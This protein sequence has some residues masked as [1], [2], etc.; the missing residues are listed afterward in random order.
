LSAAFIVR[1]GAAVGRGVEEVIAALVGV[2]W[3][4]LMVAMI[5]R[6]IDEEAG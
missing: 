3:R 2:R 5:K 6:L 4:D 1:S